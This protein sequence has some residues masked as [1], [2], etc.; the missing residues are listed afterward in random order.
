VVINRGR[1]PV[2]IDSLSRH[3]RFS[4]GTVL[5]AA[6]AADDSVVIRYDYCP[7]EFGSEHDTATLYTDEGPCRVPWSAGC[8]PPVLGAEQSQVTLGPVAVTD[9]ASSTLAFVNRGPLNTLTVRRVSTRTQFFNVSIPA[10]RSVEPGDTLRVPVRFHLRAFKPDAFGSYVDTC[11]IESDGG[12]GRV[13]LYGESPS[14]QLLLEPPVLSFGEVAAHDTAFATLRVL[15][16]SVNTLRIDSVRNRNR[17]FRP[18]ANRMQ[19]KNS[20]STSLTFRYTP[21]RFGAHADTVV[22]YNNSWRGPVRV[23]VVGISPFPVLETGLARVDFGAV[24]RGD[25]AGVVVQISNGSISTLRVES[26]RTKSRWFRL[27]RPALPA[28][29]GRGDTIRVPLLFLPDSV[30]HFS[31]TLVIVSNA[32]GSL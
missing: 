23:P 19:V 13:V 14:P 3:L 15:N 8:S 28:S 22:L 17:V 27:T 32:P 18:M 5:P 10:V 11:H 31:D 16:R 29:V 20:D 26:A 6:V 30:R 4:A 24:A 7:H 25:T 2:I 1:I 12:V 21:T 9:S